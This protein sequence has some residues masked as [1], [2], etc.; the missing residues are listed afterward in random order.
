MNVDPAKAKAVLDMP[1]PTSAKEFKSF[2]G[3]ASYLRRFLPG[4]AALSAPL[5]E[6]LK[7]K[8]EYK[9]EEVHRQA[10]AKIKE[11]LA[12][13]PVM[14]APIAG[15]ELKLYLAF[16]YNAIG[17]VLAQD[18]QNG[19]EKPIYYASRI[20]KE[21]EAR[22]TKAEKNC[23]ALIYLYAAKKF[24]HYM[25]AHKIKLVVGANPIRYLLSRPALPGRTAR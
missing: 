25:L 15:K 20:L 21:A 17:I 6:L 2:L 18:D 9:W 14:I 5:M 19:Q 4:L 24:R 16:N 10:F 22:Y 7:K 12:N 11:T 13:A 1:E 3:K 23:L 8:V